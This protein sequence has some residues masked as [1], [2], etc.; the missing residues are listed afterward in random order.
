MGTI[1]NNVVLIL[2]VLLI[3]SLIVYCLSRIYAS[4]RRTSAL[5][6]R[7]T[8]LLERQLCLVMIMQAA[9]PFFVLCL[10]TLLVTSSALLA[11]DLLHGRTIAMLVIWLSVVKSAATIGAVKAYRLALLRALPDCL[12]RL[13]PCHARGGKAYRR[14]D[15]VRAFTC[16]KTHGPPGRPA[17]NEPPLSSLNGAAGAAG[18]AGGQKSR[19][20]GLRP[21]APSRLGSSALCRHSKQ[22]QHCLSPSV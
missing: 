5:R 20:T 13:G 9:L 8:T 4:L 6:G 19:C 18:P 22:C 21:L 1:A 17:P 2:L 10:P 3:Y 14:E 11:V 16:T 12:W 15:T 7:A